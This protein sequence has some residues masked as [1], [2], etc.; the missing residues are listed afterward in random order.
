[1]EPYVGSK[2]LSPS[3]VP[4]SPEACED[5]TPVAKPN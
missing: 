5:L 3:F 2:T 4:Y 1:M